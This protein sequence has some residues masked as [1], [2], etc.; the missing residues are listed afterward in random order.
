MDG[1]NDKDYIVL[2][3]KRLKLL[4]KDLQKDMCA[5]LPPGGLSKEEFISRIISRL[6]SPQATVALDE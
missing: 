6:D 5:Y 4:V 3:N 1:V 2:Q